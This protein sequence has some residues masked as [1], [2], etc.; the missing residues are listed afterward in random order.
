MTRE[1]SLCLQDGKPRKAEQE[2]MSN[3]QRE[4]QLRGL[5]AGLLIHQVQPVSP[6]NQMTKVVVKIWKGKEREEKTRE[7]DG[8]FPVSYCEYDGRSRKS[9]A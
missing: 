6:Q 9:M 3:I 1:T 4:F 8:N 7:G 2:L 5:N